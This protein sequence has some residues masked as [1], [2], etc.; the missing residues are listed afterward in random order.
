MKDY[1]IDALTCASQVGRS[2]GEGGGRWRG[3]ESLTICLEM[4]FNSAQ[5]KIVIVQLKYILKG[6][7][8]FAA[9]L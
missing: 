8:P 4:E 5:F 2:A 1:Q 3:G 9:L 6:K 7:L